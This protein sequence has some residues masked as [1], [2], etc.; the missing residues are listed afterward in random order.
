MM[1]VNTW[2]HPKKPARKP[3][4]AN[5]LALLFCAGVSASAVGIAHV[6]YTATAEAFYEAATFKMPL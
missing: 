3:W 6:A 2:R 5:T 1:Q 4:Q